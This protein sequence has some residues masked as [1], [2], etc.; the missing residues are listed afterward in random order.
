MVSSTCNAIAPPARPPP[1]RKSTSPTPRSASSYPPAT[2]SVAHSDSPGR[3]S[4][5]SPSNR[6]G[7]GTDSV[8]VSPCTSM[9]AAFVAA[10]SKLNT[11]V[12]SAPPSCSRIP[13]TCVATST[14]MTSPWRGPEAMRLVSR[15]RDA[16]PRT[17]TIGPSR[18][19]SVVR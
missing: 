4:R 5:T 1:R 18:C 17:A 14:G 10:A 2:G 12:D 9:G 8:P 3:R 7:S 19:T 15:G 11:T 16:A 6:L 13:V